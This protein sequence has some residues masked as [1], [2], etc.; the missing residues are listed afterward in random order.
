MFVEW[1]SKTTVPTPMSSQS[2]LHDLPKAARS[3][4]PHCPSYTLFSHYLRSIYPVPSTVRGTLWRTI[5]GPYSQ[6]LH[7]H[8]GRQII[9]K[10]IPANT[11]KGSPG[12]TTECHDKGSLSV[13]PPFLLS[14]CI[15]GIFFFS[16]ISGGSLLV[17][18]WEISTLWFVSTM[19]QN[20]WN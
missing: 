3:C 11:N 16:R 6:S 13:S 14:L 9:D 4:H 19:K 1:R 15:R 17:H 10:K 12:N 7:S 5:P 20:I 8:W 18:K 2:C